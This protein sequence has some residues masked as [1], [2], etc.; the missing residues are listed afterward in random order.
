MSVA[1]GVAL[2]ALIRGVS[3][4]AHE[5]EACVVAMLRGE[6][7]DAEAAAF[8]TALR[9]KGETADELAG[10]VRAV[11]SRVE[12]VG[13]VVPKSGLL[14]TCGTGGD[15]ANTVNVSSAT[16]VVV[17]ACGVPVAKHGNRSASGNSGSSE[18]F[19]E[20]GIAIDAEPAIL[21]RCLAELGITFLLAPKFHPGLKGVA[22]VRR[23]LPFRT[24]F[25]LVGPLANPARPD[26]QLVG[27][28]GE[29][30]ADLV[31]GAFLRLGNCRAAVV[32][33]SD[34]LDEVTL[35]GS[36]RVRLV[37]AGEIVEH[38]WTPEM[39]G[40]D[41]IDIADL[42]VSGPSDSAA[43]ICHVFAGEPGPVRDM[44][45]ANA[46]AALWV[47]EKSDLMAGIERAAQAIDSGAA[48][49]LVQRWRELSRA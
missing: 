28:A 17:A 7:D 18:V 5:S 13:L 22:P 49:R 46:A 16:A 15:G 4:E 23:R 40:L 32:T 44:I 27:V 21:S 39:F 6:V 10:A 26:Y 34:G 43:R 14:D 47:A 8:L 12:D 37:D 35:G 1:I 20:L 30:E 48:A 2:K 42:R 19:A 25:N 24:L 29:R 38:V 31:A 9:M 45:L 3:L 41:P 33:G 36:T 11:R